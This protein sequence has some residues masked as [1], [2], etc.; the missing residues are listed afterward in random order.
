M[1]HS[2]SI[3]ISRREEGVNISQRGIGV[4]GTLGILFVGLKLTNYIDWPW[5]VVTMPF[6]GIPAAI[7]GIVIVVVVISGATELGKML[8]RRVQ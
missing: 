1:E 4:V 2:V 7:L 3:K 8:F 5:W 6:W